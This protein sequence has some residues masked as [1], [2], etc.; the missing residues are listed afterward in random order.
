MKFIVS[1]GL[2]LKNLQTISG[3]LNSNTPLPILENFLFDIND[4]ELII[5]A[6]DL[7]TTMTTKLSVEARENGKI[8]I[9]ASILLETLKTFPEMPLTFTINRKSTRLNSSHL[10]ISYAVFCL[11]KQK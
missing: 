5:S 8:A 9:P 11:K 1:S 2:L 10:G 4:G 6:S 3:V 7:E